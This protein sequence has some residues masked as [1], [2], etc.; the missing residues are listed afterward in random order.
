[1]AGAASGD[2]AKSICFAQ[3][4]RMNFG[5]WGRRAH[6]VGAAILGV[7]AFT[8]VLMVT[9]PP[10]PG[11]DP[12]AMA[13]MGAAESVA[14]GDGYR[15]PAAD[16]WSADSTTALTHFPPGYSTLLALPV[17]LGMAPPQAARL[18]DAG[19][20]AVTVGVAVMLVAESATLAAG[21]LLGLALLAMPAMAL[22]HLSVLSEPSF[23]ACVVLTLAAMTRRRDRP[24]AVG[25]L[26]AAATLLRYAGVALAGAGALWMAARPGTRRERLRRAALALAP[27]L[28]AQGVWVLR[29][30]VIARREP[31][32]IRRVAV[33]GGLART[34]A[35]GGA[36][37][38]DWLVPDPAAGSEP[39]PWR[40]ALA[41]AA[42]LVV[43]LLLVAGWRRARAARRDAGDDGA[44]LRLFAAGALLA[45]CYLGM[46]V[47]SRLFAD[48]GIPF[49]ER[50]LA[51]ALLLA[52]LLA[53]AAAGRAWPA[54]APSRGVL[55][56]ALAAW[57]VGS[58]STTWEQARFALDWG[59]DFAG[60][61]WRR[62]ALLA[63][64]RTG[65]AAHP[66]YTNW[67]AAVYFHLHRPARAV[68]AVDDTLALEAFADTLRA[69]DGRALLF[70]VGADA[71]VTGAQLARV[72]ALEV[73]EE[74]EDGLVLQARENPSHP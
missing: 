1:M 44:A 9:D 67:P 65:G 15:V 43:G 38:R 16:W 23:L 33:Y 54:R 35:Q 58:A 50:I 53:A 64:A 3:D 40:P 11:L 49:D 25:L 56:V 57:W 21:V 7:V 46:L 71:Y 8:L 60:E 48:P 66:L 69:H 13:Y 55:A 2:A 29:A 27:T 26:A 17:A 20:A 70:A 18:V 34:L 68:P 47:V 45:A 24:L 63:W 31:A 19:A 39:M 5:G 41:A 42:A 52:T 72:P 74:L 12:D 4:E 32:E 62:G 30:A 14:G 61:Q 51:P 36:T 22:V 73:V 10:G 6:L 37:L 28:V 59:S